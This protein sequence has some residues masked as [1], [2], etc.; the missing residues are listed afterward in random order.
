MTQ[1]KSRRS[2]AGMIAGWILAAACLAWVFHDVRPGPFLRTLVG[3]NWPLA[4]LALLVE[5]GSYFVMGARWRILLKPGLPVS[6][7]HTTQAIYS[8]LFLN[9]I[10]PFRV[11]ELGRGILIS[12]RSGLNL[13]SILPSMALERFF[14]A[15]WMALGL[16]ALAPLVPLPRNLIQAGKVLGAAIVALAVLLMVV[17]LRKPRTKGPVPP[18]R[19]EGRIRRLAKMFLRE[20]QTELRDIGFGR[21]FFLAFGL[22]LAAICLWALTFWMIMR[23]S[24]IREPLLVGFAVWLI[25]HLGIALPNSPG[26]VG[27]YQF[28]CV[29][30][31]L[32]F[33][34]DKTA[35][36]SFSVT[37]FILVSIPQVV[38][39]AVCLA[40]S[41]MTVA[42]LA[43]KARAF[44]GR[45]FSPAEPLPEG[46]APEADRR[47][48]PD[49]N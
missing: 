14:E 32:L 48:G 27:A 6:A 25:T 41:G 16:G 9:Q 35:A 28:F 47:T 7:L 22:S 45:A 8:G 46:P 40:R 31:L 17:V 37:V 2:P 49:P 36:T 12:H 21:R 10:L 13:L 24:G 34:A 4:V 42:S 1:A 39:G 18:A 44:R 15:F 30:A 19:P 26:N 33:G 3:F 43:A 5:S 11:G 29:L 20:L 38:L 23:A